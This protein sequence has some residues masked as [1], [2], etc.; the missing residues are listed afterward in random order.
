MTAALVAL[1][2]TQPLTVGVSLWLITRY[3]SGRDQLE[4]HDRQVWANRVQA[5]ETAVVQTLADDEEDRP[6]ATEWTE[7]QEHERLMA[8]LTEGG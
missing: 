2:L 3:L 5:P 6:P 7:M 4:A 1:A 8:S